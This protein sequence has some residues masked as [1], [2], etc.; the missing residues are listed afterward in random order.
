MMTIRYR[1]APTVTPPT[2]MNPR[3]RVAARVGSA[4]SFTTSF[5]HAY[6]PLLSWIQY[7]EL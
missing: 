6:S 4:T 3:H 7:P 1:I 5:C 2:M